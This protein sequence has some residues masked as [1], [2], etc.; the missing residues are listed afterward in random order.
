MSQPGIGPGP[1]WLEANTLE[2]LIQTAYLIAI[3][4]LFF[5]AAPVQIF[6]THGL[7]PGA[8]ARM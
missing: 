7:V 3:W 4:N 1:P 2:R 5:F 6:V 8:Q